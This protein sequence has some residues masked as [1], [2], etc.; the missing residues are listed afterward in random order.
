MLLVIAADAPGE[1]LV[2]I[3]EKNL[4]RLAVGQ[5]ATCIA[6]A[7]PGRPFAATVFHIAPGIDPSRGTVDVRLRLDPEA[8]FVRQDMTV[9][10]TIRTA[11]RDRALI[12][13]ADALLD[14]RDGSNHATVLAVR[15]GRVR[16][17]PVTLGLRGLLMVEVTAGLSA[18]EHILAA[19]A[20]DAE[21]VPKEGDRVR[22][23]SQALP[24]ADSA[25]RRELPVRFD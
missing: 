6:D 13:P 12:V 8:D 14:A 20:I 23:D 24:T 4:S 22:I 16:R 3:D 19:A 2:P 7:F 21:A 25:T 11:Q 9:T 10:A 1:M 5:Q 17:T 15:D 18:G